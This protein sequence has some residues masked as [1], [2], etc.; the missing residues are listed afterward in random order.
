MISFFSRI[1]GTAFLIQ[2]IAKKTKKLSIVCLGVTLSATLAACSDKAPTSD[3]TVAANSPVQTG[4][5]EGVTWPANPFAPGWLK[6]EELKRAWDRFESS[7]PYRLAL[8]SDRQLSPAAETR[9]KGNGENQ[10]IPFI[11]W[12]GI[13]GLEKSGDKDVLIAIVVDPARSDVKRYGLVVFAAAASEGPKYKVYW[14][15]RDE[16]MESY[17]L[18]P[19]SGSVFVEEYRRDGTNETKQLVWDRKTKGFLLK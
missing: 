9:V 13:T 14:V 18:S 19:A 8:P 11:A 12:W 7:Q 6:N 10:V 15:A 17:L 5:P 4:T 1:S 3:R 16:D 2:R